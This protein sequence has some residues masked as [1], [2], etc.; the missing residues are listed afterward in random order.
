MTMIDSIY[1]AALE[2]KGDVTCQL[3]WRFA[4]GLGS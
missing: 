1:E 4:N 3:Q 2:R